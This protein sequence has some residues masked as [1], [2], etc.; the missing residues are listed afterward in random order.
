[1]ARLLLMTYGTRGDVQ[2][3]IVLGRELT[4]RGHQV[5]L[6]APHPFAPDITAA[7]LHPVPLPGDPAA[8]ARQLVVEAGHNPAGMIAVITR[9]VV[10]IAG[11]VNREL[12]QAADAQAP[13]LIVHTFLTTLAGHWSAHQRGIPDVSVQF[14]PAFAP[15]GRYPSPVTPALRLGATA[16]WLSHRAVSDLYFANSLLMYRLLRWRGVDLVAPGPLPFR[17]SRHIPLA[18]AISPHVL[19]PDPAWP[20]CIHTTGYLAE[21]PPEDYAPPRDLATFLADGPPPVFIGYGSVVEDENAEQT[22]IALAALAATGQR[23]LIQSTW[24][25]LREM[26]LPSTVLTIDKVPHNW[27]FPRT[28]AVVHHGGAGTTAAGLIAGVPSVLVPFTTDQPFWGQRVHQLG[29]G[30]APIRRRQLSAARLTA[31]LTAATSDGAMRTRASDLGS[32][33]RNENGPAA[34]ADRIEAE[35]R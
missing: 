15:T 34:L 22:R 23:G 5:Q 12:Q 17:R 27:L 8:L 6:A 20:A 30:P 33:L 16:N 29:V 13:D 31:A 25:G 28:A 11:A 35:L 18:F 4:R 32:R 7:G 14:F 21:P 3:F 9:Y 1:M 24:P 10:R 19:P 2:P 26:A